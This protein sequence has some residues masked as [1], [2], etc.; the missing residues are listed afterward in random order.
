MPLRNDQGDEVDKET[1][2]AEF[3]HA[4]SGLWSKP[5][6]D[7]ASGRLPPYRLGDAGPAALAEL[8]EALPSDE[9]IRELC[10]DA[11]DLVIGCAVHVCSASCFKYHSTGSSHI[12]RHNFF[13]VV[14]LCG[15]DAEQEVCIRR[16]GKALRG[17]RYGGVALCSG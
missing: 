10:N 3:A 7:W 14:T 6:A 2:K 4:T 5:L 15:E 9:W 17:C 16:R 12:C 1:W 8:K 13:H 11:R